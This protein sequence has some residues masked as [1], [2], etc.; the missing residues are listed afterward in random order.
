MMNGMNSNP[1]EAPR[2]DDDEIRPADFVARTWIDVAAWMF[3]AT[4]VVCLFAFAFLAKLVHD[5]HRSPKDLFRPGWNAPPG[6]ESAPAQT[7]T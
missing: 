7:P 6:R 5:T 2:C 1:Y 4:V 3:L